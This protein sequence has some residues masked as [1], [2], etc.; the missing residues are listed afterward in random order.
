MRFF[1][2]VF[3]LFSALTSFGQIENPV[4]WN[5]NATKVS[6]GEYDLIYK[7]KIDDGWFVYSQYLESDEGPIPTTLNMMPTAIIN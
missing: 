4:E 1:L 5:M 3:A 2:V 6:D 7:A